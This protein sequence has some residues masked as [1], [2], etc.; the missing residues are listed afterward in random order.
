[1]NET[2]AIINI[3]DQKPFISFEQAASMRDLLIGESIYHYQVELFEEGNESAG[4]VVTRN[5]ES[6]ENLAT[7]EVIY[8]WKDDPSLSDKKKNRKLYQSINKQSLSP[9]SAN[10]FVVHT[11]SNGGHCSGIFR[12]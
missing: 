1:M 3:I 9:R 12:S 4:F 5:S 10:L 6:Q 7:Q 11:L 8:E 2:Q